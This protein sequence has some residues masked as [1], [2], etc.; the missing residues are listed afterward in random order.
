MATSSRRRPQ[1]W[2]I[3]P[4]TERNSIKTYDKVSVLRVETTINNPA[5]FRVLSLDADGRPRPHPMRKGVANLPEYFAQGRAANDRYLGALATMPD[6]R[7]AQQARRRLCRPRTHQGHRHARFSPST[8]T[9]SHYSGPP[10]RRAPPHRLPQQ[11]PHPPALP[12]PGDHTRR[13]PTTLRP[14]LATDR[15]TRGHGLI[16]KIPN[17]VAPSHRTRPTRDDSRPHHQRQLPQGLRQQ[18]HH[19]LGRHQHLADHANH[20]RN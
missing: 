11:G 12:D 7:Q 14:N 4:R 19:D 18:P 1:G 10:L 8:P 15:Q 16:A 5:Q 13:S 9:T 20:R 17:D 3:K 6:Q 2:R